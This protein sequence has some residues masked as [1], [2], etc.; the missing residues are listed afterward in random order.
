[1]DKSQKEIFLGSLF[2]LVSTIS[3]SA[4]SVFA[5][6]AYRELNDSI[7]MLF[8][9]M[10]LALPFFLIVVLKKSNKS[11]Q[12]TRHDKFK[13]L[14]LG[15]IGY[16]LASLFDFWGL[17]Y[18][19]AGMERVIL[20][21]Y[22][23]IVVLLGSLIYKR[24]P[25][26]KQVYALLITYSG[27]LLIFIKER[28]WINQT[29]LLGGSLVFLSAF[30]YSLYLLGSEKLIAKMGGSKYTA[31]ALTI[32]G[33][34]VILHFLVTRDVSILWTL[35]DRVYILGLLM[36]IVSTVIPTFFLTQGIKRI[37]SAQS[38]ILGTLGPV[39]TIILGY[40]FL[41]E[42]IGLVEVF[43]TLLILAGVVIV[44]LEKK[45]NATE[46]FPFEHSETKV[47]EEKTQSS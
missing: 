7:T 24:K 8:L 22:P 9:R 38:A 20:F 3:F 2:V 46:N 14:F 19:P 32:S 43:G 44:S 45:E 5:K 11:F 15:V 42:K 1:M 23:T 47:P 33:I 34:C 4:K 25:T 10:S 29:M 28:F 21:I 26:K 35:S 13:I 39:S 17:E 37:G 6:L 31:Y 18:I 12:L 30:S 41:D 40:F 27:I 16:Y 36:A